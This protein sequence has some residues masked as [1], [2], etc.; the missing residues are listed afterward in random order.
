M[1]NIG[2][3]HIPALLNK[4]IELLKVKPDC[5]YIDATL[6]GGGH[7]N[8]IVNKGGN[9]LAIDR[10]PEAIE[11]SSTVI[12]DIFKEKSAMFPGQKPPIFVWDNFLNIDKIV[13]SNGFKPI[14]GILFDLGVSS[15][16]LE[17]PQ[18]G[19][20]FNQEGPLDMRMDPRLTVT[21]EDLINGLNQG[22]L[23]ELFLKL[24]EEKFSKRIAAT[25]CSS[26]VEKKIT[27]CDQLAQIILKTVPRKGKFD[28]TH[29]ATRVFQALRI[30]VNDEINAL[31]ESLPKSAEMLN[32]NGRLVVLSF[33]SLEDGIVKRFFSDQQ[34]R[35]VLKIITE[36]PIVPS[37]E[38]IS[39]N[40]RARSAKLRAAEKII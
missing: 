39:I 40:P 11:Y 20:S 17:V 30:A 38:E 33:H 15:H 36:K 7:S 19:F 9:L 10:D 28:R 3:Y 14:D 22:E 2:T 13:E 16:Q 8:E 21:A 4:T 37:D 18:R 26:R 32:T 27:T 25:I 1:K 34:T 24:G 35:E 29:P 31:K 12:N 5:N 23:S 6:G